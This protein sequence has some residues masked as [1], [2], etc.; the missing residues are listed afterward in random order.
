MAR[1]FTWL[2]YSHWFTC[3]LLW[4]KLEAPGWPLLRAAQCQS[5]LTLL[6]LLNPD[7][8]LTCP[9][10]CMCLWEW[11]PLS[12]CLHCCQSVTNREGVVYITLYICEL[13]ILH[14]KKEEEKREKA[15][16][17]LQ[18]SLDVNKEALAKVCKCHDMWSV[19]F[20]PFCWSGGHFLF[21]PKWQTLQR[22]TLYKKYVL[23]C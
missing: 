14:K 17:T 7:I 6:L 12:L 13:V 22:F 3:T 2:S 11:E 21:N 1:A 4:R 5:I 20:S 15:A 19:F 8:L 9:T 23:M 10:P 16:V 18:D